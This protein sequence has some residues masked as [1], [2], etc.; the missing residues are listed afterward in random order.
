MQP[1]N[2][3]KYPIAYKWLSYCIVAAFFYYWLFTTGL[4]FFRK[5]ITAVSPRQTAVYNAFW[6]QNWKLFASTYIYNRELK[7]VLR[8]KLNPAESDTVALVSYAVSEKR[9]FA[10]FNNYE[11]ALD[12]LLYR[13]MNGL[14][15][16]LTAKKIALQKQFPNQPDSFYMQQSS[17]LTEGDSLHQTDLQNLIS[18]GKY[19]LNKKNIDTTGKE[20]QLILVYE[21][22]HPQVP[23]ANVVANGNAAT[24]FISTFKNL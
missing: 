13:I 7:L 22:I 10:P 24:F 21:Y 8:D 18:Y 11:D 15:M 2:T 1:A 23:P 6:R 9:K 19:V 16:Q 12:H 3:P 14:E 4:I 20:F 17:L 5:S